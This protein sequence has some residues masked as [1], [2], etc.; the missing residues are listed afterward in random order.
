MDRFNRTEVDLIRAS[1]PNSPEAATGSVNAGP[2]PLLSGLAAHKENVMAGP[3][4]NLSKGRD[5]AIHAS[6]LEQEYRRGCPAQG[7]A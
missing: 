6:I 3:A 2:D 7:R 4:L 5:P 1:T